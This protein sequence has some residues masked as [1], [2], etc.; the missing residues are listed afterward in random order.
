MLE[1]FACVTTHFSEAGVSLQWDNIRQLKYVERASWIHYESIFILLIFLITKEFLYNTWVFFSG[2][3]PL[4]CS[5]VF[6]QSRLVVGIT[7]GTGYWWALHKLSHISSTLKYPQIERR[8]EQKEMPSSLCN[9]K[10]KDLLSVFLRCPGLSEWKLASPMPVDM[11]VRVPLWFSRQ[12]SRDK[13]IWQ[14]LVK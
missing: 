7:A 12:L 4:F 10:N 11:P 8:R 14:D 5:L 2:S 13:V 1:C 3:S 6:S 9:D